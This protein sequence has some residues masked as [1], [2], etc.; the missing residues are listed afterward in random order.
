[1][2]LANGVLTV[3]LSPT[4]E[5]YDFPCV[6]VPPVTLPLR[7]MSLVQATI[8]GVEFSVGID[9]GASHPFM[10]YDLAE[11]LG[12]MSRI[13]RFTFMNVQVLDR[14]EVVCVGHIKDLIVHLRRGE[15]TVAEVTRHVRVRPKSV[16]V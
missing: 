16:L 13:M 5:F 12:L 4:P 1:M 7:R 10:N 15:S 8:N 6:T 3:Y 11:R 9:S 14:E 2:T